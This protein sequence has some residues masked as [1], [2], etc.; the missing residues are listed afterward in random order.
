MAPQPAREVS[1]P[2]L[3]KREAIIDAAIEAFGAG[4][5]D[6]ATVE[7]I[8]RRAGIA[9]GT[10]YLYFKSREEIFNSVLRERW[11][12]PLPEQLLRG[13]MD[14][15]PLGP[16]GMEEAMTRLSLGFLNAVESNMPVFRLLLTAAY[17][18]PEVGDDL[19]ENAFLKVN[20]ML[21][22]ILERQQQAG[23]V[24][25]LPSPLITAR[26][27]Q[28]MLMM[29]ILSQDVLNGRKFTPIDKEDWVRESVRLFLHGVLPD[30]G[31]GASAGGKDPAQQGHPR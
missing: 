14:E 18:F 22:S 9:K 5:L 21:A 7:E 27:L 26:C 31:A 4:G 23:T 11:P 25:S 20:R 29:Y 16:A 17:Q 10:V 8:A 3:D 30:R 28:G 24:R 1:H 12:G 15:P 6:G 19:Y 2:R 13:L